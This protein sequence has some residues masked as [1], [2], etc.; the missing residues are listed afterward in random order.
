MM[1]WTLMTA[2]AECKLGFAAG[3]AWLDVDEVS[4]TLFVGEV[5][6]AVEMM[7]RGGDLG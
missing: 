5:V 6:P 2:K 4:S 1:V 7:K 3:V